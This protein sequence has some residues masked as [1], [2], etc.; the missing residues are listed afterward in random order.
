MRLLGDRL[1]LA[2]LPDREKTS[3]GIILPQGQAGDVRHYWKVEA[4]GN[5]KRDKQGEL[6]A[7]EF[8]VGDVVITP[9][10]HENVVLEDGTH[11]RIVGCEQIIAKM[12]SAAVPAEAPATPV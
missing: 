9:L 10:Y 1:L 2:P 12:E 3:N 4:V 8:S 6:R 11:R 7:P 5:G